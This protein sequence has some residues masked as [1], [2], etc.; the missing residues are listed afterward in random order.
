MKLNDN[1]IAGVLLFVLYLVLGLLWLI[2]VVT[3]DTGK[4]PCEV[5]TVE[6]RAY[7]EHVTGRP[8]R[9]WE[10]WR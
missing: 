1:L 7:C 10:M 3:A 6:Q 8:A 5:D 2:G 4:T 9:A